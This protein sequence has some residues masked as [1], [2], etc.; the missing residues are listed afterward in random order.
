MKNA[1]ATCIVLWLLLSP[2]AAWAQTQDLV[3]LKNLK[4]VDIPFEFSN[5]FIVV[6]V[7][8]NDI[9]PLNFIIDTGA[10]HSILTKREIAD[11]LQ[12]NFSRRFPIMGA[13][14]KTELYAY[15]A[16]GIRLKINNLY[17]NNYSMLVLEDDYFRF[18]EFSGVDIHGI[19]G[20]DM[21]RRFVVKI[22]YEKKVITFTDPS[23][24]KEPGGKFVEIP[25]QLK[26]N[27]PYVFSNIQLQN[28]TVLPVKLL[29]DTGAGVSLM[30][31]S[32]THPQIVVPAN[33]VK[34]NLGMGIGGA[35][36][37]VVG[38]L[39]ALELYE[40]MTMNGVV[41]NYQD[42]KHVTDT[43]YLN[44]RHGIIGNR[45]LSRFNLI[46]NYY[47]NKVYLQPNKLSKR[48]FTYDRS[49]LTIVSSGINLNTFTVLDVV[50]GSPADHAGIKAGDEIRK[51]NGFPTK[52]YSLE[53][54]TNKM[55]GRIGKKMT[56]ILRRNGER[57][58]TNFHL[59]ELI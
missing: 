38:R 2:F 55:Q 19:I 12:V 13:D 8:F 53:E 32:D 58:K 1:V 24:F 18:D 23:V 46:I 34:S 11:L 10:E 27:K 56:L 5:N 6:K 40:G 43:S 45:I 50:A 21:L 25:V 57:V 31:H 47:Q 30:L 41:T 49:G 33:V 39:P 17:F 52:V 35:I 9:F 51:I 36:E 15:L 48:R 20:A 37:G 7:I 14:M 59:R 29:L 22:N 4:R 54:I 16:T 42:I 28:N 26:R 3:I 44:G